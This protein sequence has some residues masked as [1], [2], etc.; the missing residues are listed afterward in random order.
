MGKFWGKGGNG[1]KAE[2]SGGG[3]TAD[4]ADVT[5]GGGGGMKLET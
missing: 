4:Y 1:E 3:L 2:R 5:D